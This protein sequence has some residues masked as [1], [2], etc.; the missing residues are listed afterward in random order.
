MSAANVSANAAQKAGVAIDPRQR[1]HHLIQ[2]CA[3]FAGLPSTGL[4]VTRNSAAD[5]PSAAA[6]HAGLVR[7]K[8]A[9]TAQSA[10]DGR[11]LDTFSIG[12]KT[13]D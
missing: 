13:N 12:Q 10:P 1:R 3:L 4:G 11:A 7:W 9:A 6:I 5:W 2:L 8:H